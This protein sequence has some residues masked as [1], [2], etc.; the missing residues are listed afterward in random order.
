MIIDLFHCILILDF[1]SLKK[2]AEDKGRF[3]RI[4]SRI[5]IRI[6]IHQPLFTTTY[7]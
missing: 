4:R 6:P 7:N 1:F 3:S 5:R 2:S